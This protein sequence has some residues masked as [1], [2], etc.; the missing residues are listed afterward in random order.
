M[1]SFKTM[2]YAKIVGLAFLMA[3]SV[4]LFM[5]YSNSGGRLAT[6]FIVGYVGFSLCILILLPILGVRNAKH[7][8]KAELKGK[9]YKFLSVFL[10]LIISSHLLLMLF[11]PAKINVL[12]EVTNALGVALGWSF[13]DVLLFKKVC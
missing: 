12:T 4:V 1:N 10:V 7:F 5:V 9:C 11:A 6:F 3:T 2:N 8:S 13:I